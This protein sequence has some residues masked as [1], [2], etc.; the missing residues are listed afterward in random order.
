MPDYA[1]RSWTGLFAPRGTPAPVLQRLSAA[2]R[3]ILEQPDTRRRLLELG[4]EPI[5]SDPAATDR[6]VREEYERW[7]PVVRA[8][9]VTRD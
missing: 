4:S 5:W 3:E 1:V 9:K 6:F 2:V 7:G 8:A